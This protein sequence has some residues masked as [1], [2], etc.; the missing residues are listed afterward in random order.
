[1]KRLLFVLAF[2]SILLAAGVAA[3]SEYDR[4]IVAN[5]EMGCYSMGAPNSSAENADD[6][7]EAIAIKHGFTLE[8]LEALKAKY[9]GSQTVV[10]QEMMSQCPKQMGAMHGMGQSDQ[11][12]GGRGGSH[13]DL[14]KWK[15]Q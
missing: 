2:V 8:E 1:M 6:P 3:G 9:P 14:D 10:G 11:W 12:K 15:Q 5:A 4:F 7:Y 13:G